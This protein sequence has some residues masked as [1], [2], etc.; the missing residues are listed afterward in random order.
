MFI[1]ATL[2]KT[3]TLTASE[4]PEHEAQLAASKAQEMAV[5]IAQEIIL[6]TY[7]VGIS[8]RNA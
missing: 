3:I 6:R 7:N 5:K 2:T 4:S 1:P 8:E